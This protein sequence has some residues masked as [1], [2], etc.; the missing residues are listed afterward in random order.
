[1]RLT[2]AQKAAVEERYGQ[3]TLKRVEGKWFVIG[4]AVNAP[5]EEC[6]GWWALQV[7]S[8]DLSKNTGHYRIWVSQVAHGVKLR[9]DVVRACEVAAVR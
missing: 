8:I 3:G 7:E 2:P 6:P 5:G 4:R 9:R 1:M